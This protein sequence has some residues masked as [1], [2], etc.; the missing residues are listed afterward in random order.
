MI[1]LNRTIQAVNNSL[2]LSAEQFINRKLAQ[3]TTLYTLFL[4][5]PKDCAIF[6]LQIG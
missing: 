5:M 3:R 2:F 1:P 4:T 6:A